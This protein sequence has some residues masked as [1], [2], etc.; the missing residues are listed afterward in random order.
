MTASAPPRRSSN[1]LESNAAEC[2]KAV[3]DLEPYVASHYLILDETTRINLELTQ[4][5]QGER[6]DT[7]LA[8]IDRTLTPMGGRR[9][10]QWLLYPLLDPPAIRDRLEGVQELVESFSDA[11]GIETGAP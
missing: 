3:R 2:V 1:Y 10:R 11:P 5:Y 7:L 8:V 4:N 6:K 9:L